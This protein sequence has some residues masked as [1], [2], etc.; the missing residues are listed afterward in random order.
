MPG[1]LL[2]TL[3]MSTFLFSLLP[4]PAHILELTMVEG[5]GRSKGLGRVKV[6]RKPFLPVGAGG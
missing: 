3:V 1:R 4:L 2:L 6:Y 5:E